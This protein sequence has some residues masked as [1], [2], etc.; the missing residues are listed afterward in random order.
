MKRA[1]I[2][3]AVLFAVVVA[4]M[5]GYARYAK[6]KLRQADAVPT[7]PQEQQET[8]PI[9]HIDAKHYYKDGEHTIAG[10]IIMPTPCDLLKAK[11]VV[12]ESAPVHA[13]VDLSIINNT[14]GVCVQM[15]TPQRFK[16]SFKG[17]ADAKIDAT[18]NGKPVTLNL[19]M[20][21]PDENPDDFEVFLKG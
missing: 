4:G 10:E 7:A 3:A 17:G 20:A 21:R 8:Q 6:E 11:A 14:Q 12:N 18:L 13:T 1:L 15:V 2:V 19:I 5:F 16:V 9:T